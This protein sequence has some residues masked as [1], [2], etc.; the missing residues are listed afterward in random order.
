[1]IGLV[2]DIPRKKDAKCVY[3]INTIRAAI[4]KNIAS[5]KKYHNQEKLARAERDLADLQ[6][7]SQVL[8]RKLANAV[9]LGKFEDKDGNVI[10]LSDDMNNAFDSYAIKLA[11]GKR[12]GQL[13]TVVVQ[14]SSV[15]TYFPPCLVKV[16][17]SQHSSCCGIRTAEAVAKISAEPYTMKMPS[18][19]VTSICYTMQ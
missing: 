19:G 17:A 8:R 18:C 9:I 3:R 13:Q 2:D 7:D 5:A 10:S 1:V 15:L 11:K 14:S 6:A 4:K 16:V 12:S